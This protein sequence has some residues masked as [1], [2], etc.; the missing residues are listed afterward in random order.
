MDGLI[1]MG[2]AGVVTVVLVATIAFYFGG[3]FEK[4]TAEVNIK[5]IPG[6]ISVPRA[7]WPPCYRRCA[8]AHA[9][10]SRRGQRRAILGLPAARTGAA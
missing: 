2:I 1:S 9:L 6:P 3:V 8:K 4:F 5:H 7:P 10:W